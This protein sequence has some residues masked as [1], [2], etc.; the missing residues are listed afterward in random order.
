MAWARYDYWGQVP[1]TY[2]PATIPDEAR[3]RDAIRE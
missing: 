2:A 3:L 1:M